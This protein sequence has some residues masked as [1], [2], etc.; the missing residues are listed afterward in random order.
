[1]N[2]KG[3]KALASAT[4]MSLVLTTALATG[5][6][7]AAAGQV[8][9]VGGTDRYET[10]AKVATAN[11]A[12]GSENVILVNGLSYADSVSASALAKT[13]NAP[14]LLTTAD[15]LNADAKDA[16]NT[17]K[18]KNVYIVGG[19]AAVSKSVADSLSDYS[20]TRLS[21]ANRYAT[22]LA[23]AN[24]LV[25]N[26][27]V[28][29]DNLLVVT[30]QA[31]S[32]A[33]SA[34]PVA[35][36]KGEI[37]LLSTNDKTAMG[38]TYDFAKD[39]NVTVIGTTNSVDAATY[40]SLNADKRVD[41]GANRFATNLN[42]LDTF[43][44]DLKADK[45]Y[46]ATA[47]PNADGANDTQFADALVASAIAGKYSA[48]LVLTNSDADTDTA[49]NNAISYIGKTATKDT[50]LQVVGGTG[51]VSDKLVGKINDAVPKAPVEPV[52]DGTV[53]S[54]ETVKDQYVNS[55]ADD[56]ALQFT[57]N[58]GIKVTAQQIVD[59]G[60][61][62]EF[63]TGT[64]PDKDDV[65][66][67]NSSNSPYTSKDG[68]LDKT[69]LENI[70]GTNQNT[71]F[72][73]SVKITKNDQIVGQTSTE[74][75]NVINGD[76]TADSLSDLTVKEANTSDVNTTPSAVTTKINSG[77][78]VKG[79]WAAVTKVKGNIGNATDVTVT[80]AKYYSSDP[81]IA[82]VGENTGVIHAKN[83]GNFTLTVKSGTTSKDYNFTVSDDT[84]R[85]VTTAEP[86]V[87]SIKVGKNSAF[88]FTVVLKDQFGD[89]I[90]ANT[91]SG[92]DDDDYSISADVK[93]GSTTIASVSATPTPVVDNDGKATIT[94]NSTNSGSGELK[95]Y[96]KNGAIKT[97]PVEV[98]TDT[99]VDNIKVEAAASDDDSKD[100]TLDLNPKAADD[101]GDKYVKLNVNKYSSDNAYLGKITNPSQA[102]ITNPSQANIT[103]TTESGKHILSTTTGTAV[104][105][106]IV[107]A[108]PSADTGDYGTNVTNPWVLKTNGITG[109]GVN[110]VDTGDGTITVTAT[111]GGK[112]ASTKLNVK[113]TTPVISSAN[114]ANISTTTPSGLTVKDVLKASDVSAP[115]NGVIRIANDGTIF[116]KSDDNDNN[117]GSTGANID[118]DKDTHGHVIS[119]DAV[120]DITLGK[121]VISNL[122]GSFTG[123]N[124][125]PS[126]S[127]GQI[128]IGTPSGNDNYVRIGVLKVHDNTTFKYIDVKVNNN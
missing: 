82:E 40:S 27:G 95:I 58:G 2:K 15:T 65:F 79:D 76:A 87:S 80:N 8:T 124:A 77:K 86:S 84:S 21:G 56:E 13:L 110:N 30:G 19:E 63:S 59:A 93:D 39:S 22:N 117:T 90:K 108:I 66:Q 28:S 104:N 34:A 42:I 57:V 61:G 45:L 48:P 88:D 29:K 74:T 125:T 122:R 115:T 127:S 64:D 47:K 4:L 72:K 17:L 60:Y 52:F 118:G 106:D 54:V 51:V 69:K 96:N 107:V 44:D 3:T 123:D 114:L 62:I 71:T 26:H 5:N 121:L 109:A 119:Y 100:L 25:K 78:F 67:T 83:A 98:G 102:N 103:V 75:V 101:N 99:S 89:P 32:D 126:I 11:F 14:I 128:K 10:A 46:V 53:N 111:V 73:Y 92:T 112:S 16:L 18:P 81:L 36:A 85:K 38:D 116:V 1:M 105:G 6:V 70:L 68:I 7:K 35:A 113:D 20:V 37:L 31:Y 97:I 43:K 55:K 24:E 41:G 33:L 49:T 23:V 94:V 50:D 91:I 12:D 120:H 9:R